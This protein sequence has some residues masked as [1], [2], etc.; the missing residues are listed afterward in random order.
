MGVNPPVCHRHQYY[1]PPMPQFKNEFS[2]KVALI[3]GAS[4]GIGFATAKAFLEQGAKVAICAL[5]NKRLENAEKELSA[6]GEVFALPTNVGIH[7]QVN[8]F[9]EKSTQHFGRIDILINNAG[10][11]AMGE[12]AKEDIANIDEVIDT[13]VKGVLYVTHAV[14]PHMI[15]QKSGV[16]INISSGAGLSGM[17]ELATYCTSKFAGVGFTESL[18]REVEAHNIR[19]Y[20]I[21]P[22]R[23]TPGMQPEKFGVMKGMPVEQVVEAVLKL[24][25][26]K[27]S[28]KSGHY[29]TL[30]S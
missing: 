8:E 9:V 20:A 29:V 2:G 17:K 26:P 12:F 18:A 22:G 25:G 13:N 27:P 11:L 21:C 19:V 10:R 7:C 6:L 28:I 30:P 24:A 3:T 16:I 15:A 1:N 4:R 23:V 5:D 14:L